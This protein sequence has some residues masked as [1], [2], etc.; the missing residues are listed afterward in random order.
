M[1]VSYVCVDTLMAIGMWLR[2]HRKKRGDACEILDPY[3]PLTI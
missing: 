2:R 1:M 3:Q